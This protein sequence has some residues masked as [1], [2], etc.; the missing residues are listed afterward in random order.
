MRPSTIQFILRA[1]PE[2][3]ADKDLYVRVYMTVRSRLEACMNNGGQEFEYL[4]D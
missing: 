1:C 2:I 3:D 4:N